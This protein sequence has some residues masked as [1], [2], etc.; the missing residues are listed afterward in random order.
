VFDKIEQNLLLILF[1]DKSSH[2]DF[3]EYIVSISPLAIPPFT[4]SAFSGPVYRMI[5]EIG[6]GVQIFIRDKEYAAS[7]STPTPIRASLG[8]PPFSSEA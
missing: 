3:E 7:V 8:H 1:S 2:G 6:K 5:S 4:V